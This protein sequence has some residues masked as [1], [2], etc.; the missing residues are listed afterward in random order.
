MMLVITLSKEVTDQTEAQTLTDSLKQMVIG[1]PDLDIQ[2]ETHD[3]VST[4]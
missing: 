2:A 4:E 3:E 1:V